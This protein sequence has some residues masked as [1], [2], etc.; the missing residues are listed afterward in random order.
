MKKG[1]YTALITPVKN[2]SIDYEGLA[3]LISF[4]IEN[5]ITGIL[6]VGTTG[7]SPAFFWEEHKSI[8]EKTASL[9]KDKAVCIAGVGS[10]CTEETLEGAEHAVKVG[11]DALLLVDPYYN[12]PSSVEIRKEYITPIAKAFPETEIVPYVIPGRTGTQLFPQDLAILYKKFPN[13]KNV[14][15]ATGNLENMKKT[16]A[17]CG[18]DFSIFSGDD[19]LTCQMMTDPE[20]KASGVISVISNIAPKAVSDMVSYINEGEIEK[21]EKL[22]SEIAPLFNIVGV[23]TTEKTPY[24]NVVCKAKNPVPIK[25]VMQILGMPSGKCLRP[26]GRLTKQG[27]D[28]V[29][30]A[31]RKTDSK[32]PE[33]LKPA[34]EFFNVD[35]QERINDPKFIEGLYYTDY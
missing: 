20:I 1:C 12:G 3:K 25:T 26:L 21:G 24:G 8:I 17:C 35:I 18:T 5:G 23:K 28:V 27:I 9:L 6:A 34:A 11:A 16:R 31:L 13:V 22:A 19:A 30:S 10:N 32:N 15:E 29:I 2:E 4:Q 14:K 7:E 33:I